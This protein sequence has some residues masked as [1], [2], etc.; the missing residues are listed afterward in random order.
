MSAADDRIRVIVQ[1]ELRTELAP[2]IVRLDKLNGWRNKLLGAGA[3]FGF[4]TPL[5]IAVW[6]ILQ[7]S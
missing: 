5:L 2:I 1:G 7:T 3:L 4:A 6:A